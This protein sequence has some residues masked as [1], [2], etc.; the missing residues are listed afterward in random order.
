MINTYTILSKHLSYFIFYILQASAHFLQASAH[1]LQW[2]C[3]A[4]CFSHSLA[5]A[6]QHF[7]HKAQISAENCEF[8]AHNLAQRLQMSAQSRQSK[9]HSF[10]PSL[11]QA[12]EHFSH[13]AKQA[14]QAS[15]HF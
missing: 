7:T 14:K 2:S 4:E 3:W 5:Q 6:S 12:V 11:I 9:V 15:I 13:S 10:I 1:F 8:L